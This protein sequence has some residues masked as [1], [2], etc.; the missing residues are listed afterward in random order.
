M[1]GGGEIAPDTRSR[2]RSEKTSMRPSSTCLRCPRTPCQ[3][4]SPPERL[5][6]R[7]F[8]GSVQPWGPHAGWVKDA[9]LD[10]ATW[11]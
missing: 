9:T 10:P 6:P 3:T 5:P 11:E 2:C 4:R 1:E 8:P 7:A